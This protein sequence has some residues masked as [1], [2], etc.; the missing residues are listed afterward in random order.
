M[1]TLALRITL[2][3]TLGFVLLFERPSSTGAPNAQAAAVERPNILVIMTD[4]QRAS[5]DTYKMMPKIMAKVREGGT[6]FRN[7][8]ATQPLCCPSRISTFSGLYSHNHGT[9]FNAGKSWKVSEQQRSIQYQLRQNGY[10]TAI[11]G[12]FLNGWGANPP[13]FDRWATFTNYGYFGSTF[14]VNGQSVST[15]QYSTDFI[16]DRAIGF[17]NDFER[18]DSTPWLMYVH[19]W[20][21]HKPY[22]PDTQHANATI[23]AFEDSPATLEADRSDKP[24]YVQNTSTKK[25]NVLETRAKQLRSLISVDNM[26]EAIFDRLDALGEENTIIVFLSD[27]GFEWYEHKLFLK[28]YPYNESV[29]IPMFVSWP[30]QLPAGD[31]RDNIVATI[32]IAPTVYDL[33]GVTPNYTVDGKHML[34]SSREDILI[35]YWHENNGVSPPT[36][37][38]LWN[39]SWTY[40]EYAGTSVKEYYGPD[41]PWQLD[42]SFNTGDPPSNAAQLATRLRSVSTCSGAACP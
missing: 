4:D 24:T 40:I 23:P 26:G 3:L 34:S 21:P 11:T 25:S 20:A 37:T 14:N 27:N 29:R 22:T 7:A 10:S 16:R 15:N 6:E 8:V 36:W 9:R 19:P 30:G 32:D 42:N 2:V 1:L 41:D 28:R 35:E 17:L 39:P 33:V 12:K 18:S 38:S 5:A 13:N 31:A